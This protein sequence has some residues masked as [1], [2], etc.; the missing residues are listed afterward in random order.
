[1][2]QREGFS[3]HGSYVSFFFFF[4]IFHILTTFLIIKSVTSA[5]GEYTVYIRKTSP[6]DLHPLT[7]FY[8]V[9]LGFTGVY[10]IFLFCS[11][12]YIVGTR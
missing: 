10:I 5:A 4:Q 9:K 12:T 6:C 3:R 1:M 7:P 2:H 11:K 8:I